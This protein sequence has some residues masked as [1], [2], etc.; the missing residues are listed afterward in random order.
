[1]SRIEISKLVSRGKPFFKVKT[2]NGKTETSGAHECFL[3][4]KIPGRTPKQSDGIYVEWRWDGKQLIVNNDRYGIYPLFYSCFEN[5]IWISPSIQE[6]SKGNAP[7]QLDYIALSILFRLGHFIGEDTPFKY[8]RV[9]PP[10][11]T[12]TWQEGSVK[13]DRSEIT[14]SSGNNKA[15]SYA[16]AVDNYAYLFSQAIK[17]RL[18]VDENFAVPLSGGRDS[19]HILF[20]LMNQSRK[21][22]FCMTVK[23]RPPTTNED[24]RIAQLIADELEI[25]H[26]EI[27]KPASWFQAVLE[28]I[29]LTNFCGGGHSWIL[30]LADYLLVEQVDT[31][32][33]GLGGDVLS[34]GHL[35]DK[36]KLSLFQQDKLDELAVSLLINNTNENFNKNVLTRSFYNKISIDIAV[37]R[38]VDELKK[39]LSALNPVLSFT[40][41]NRTRRAISSIPFSILSDIP[42]VYCPYLDHDLYDFLASLDA[43]FFLDQDFHDETI[44]KAYPKYTYLPFE[45]KALKATF[46]TEDHI[47]YK[48]SIKNF[49]GYLMQRRFKSS[50]IIRSGYIYPK[51]LYD[52]CKKSCGNPW[53]L[54]SAL[55]SME[56]EKYC[57]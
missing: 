17:K 33:D 10:N 21:P 35:L 42:T 2:L 23:Y 9:L 31:I 54:R 24:T 36:I 49:L 41:W 28:D 56:L 27:D 51:I 48:E 7:K 53:Y 50:K 14:H 37:A 26:V 1:M 40:F 30:P 20:E 22:K 55:Y 15:I 8:I 39:H 47:F 18:P 34:N 5:E 32:Y 44:K 52:L 57:E 13:I 16:E 3:G 12:L 43:S 29:H 45:N 46:S 6:V 38:L 25:N 11:S 19:R 4:H